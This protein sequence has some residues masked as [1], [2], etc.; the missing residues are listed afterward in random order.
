[1]KTNREW[2]KDQERKRD[3]QSDAARLLTLSDLEYVGV[4]TAYVRITRRDDQPY[5]IVGAPI[6]P[7]L[8][9]MLQLHIRQV[10]FLWDKATLH[11]VNITLMMVLN[12]AF[13]MS[14]FTDLMDTLYAM[15]AL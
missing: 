5:T 11:R 14:P 7:P 10:P 15:H 6:D 8:P 3:C 12:S 2:S 9:V 13:D 4:A 1:M